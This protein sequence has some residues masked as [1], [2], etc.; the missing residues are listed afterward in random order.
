MRIK[1]RCPAGN[2]TTIS[3]EPDSTQAFPGGYPYV[4]RPGS[5]HLRTT[6]IIKW[7]CSMY[8]W[9]MNMMHTNRCSCFKKKLYVIYLSVLFSDI[10]RPQIEFSYSSHPVSWEGAPGSQKRMTTGRKCWKRLA[11]GHLVDNSMAV[12]VVLSQQAQQSPKLRFLW[13][14]W[15]KS[16]KHGGWWLGF[17][18]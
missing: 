15:V 10:P 11:L 12:I 9:N 16:S 13:V 7:T 1:P 8:E 18:H 14:K 17:R 2:I 5:L 6:R 3:C 4:F